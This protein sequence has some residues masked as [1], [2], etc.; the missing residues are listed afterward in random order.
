MHFPVEGSENPQSAFFL[1]EFTVT[2]MQTLSSQVPP[3]H[4][5]SD[6]KPEAS[7]PA[8]AVA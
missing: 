4:L 7:A 2:L 6:A 3:D 8:H 1:Q 5:S